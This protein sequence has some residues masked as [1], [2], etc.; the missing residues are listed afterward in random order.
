MSRLVSKITIFNTLALFVQ[1]Q[2]PVKPEPEVT[3]PVTIS[4][5]TT[6]IITSPG[7]KFEDDFATLSNTTNCTWSLTAPENKIIEIHTKF[8]EIEGAMPECYFDY[9]QFRDSDSTKISQKICGKNSI[10]VFQSGTN[11]LEIEFKTDYSNNVNG[12]QLGYKL[13]DKAIPKK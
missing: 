4:V 3:C 9:L 2:T 12:F 10:P 1:A 5:S 7:F 11:K 6:G 13:L 8:I